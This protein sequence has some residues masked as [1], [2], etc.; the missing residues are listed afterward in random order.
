M[1]VDIL[2]GH[3]DSAVKRYCTTKFNKFNSWTYSKS[4]RRKKCLAYYQA[5]SEGANQQAVKDTY[6]RIF[7]EAFPKPPVSAEQSPMLVNPDDWLDHQKERIADSRRVLTTLQM[8]KDTGEYQ[9]GEEFFLRLKQLI[10]EFD[11]SL[12]DS[13]ELRT[14]SEA[15][16]V[17]NLT[18]SSVRNARDV[19]AQFEGMIGI[20]QNASVVFE[21]YSPNW[22]EINAKLEE[23]FKG[24]IWTSG[25]AKA[26]IERLGF[27]AEVQAAIAIGAQLTIAGECSWKKG[28]AGLELGGE[29]QAFAGARAELGGKLSVSALKG[30]EL[31][32]KGGAFVGVSASATG[33]VAFTYGDE[34]LVRVTAEATISVGIGAEFEINIAAPIFGPSKVK[35]KGEVTFGVGGGSAVELEVNF[36]E[37]GLA[38]SE[39]FRKV[40][41]LPTL[42]KGY[43]MTLM[44][45][46]RRNKHYLDKC[47][48]RLGDG[49]EEIEESLAAYHNVPVEKRRL[50]MEMDY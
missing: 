13:R 31:A 8:W 5:A 7:K 46:D 35:V 17:S 43:K 16:L 40:V 32:L 10:A 3:S 33:T 48:R 23:E 47:Q 28:K 20:Q 4:T 29:C 26:K 39:Q 21:A 36:T 6:F 44:T 49:M 25:E 24:G 11:P 37:M 45:S 34:D 22:G 41:Y 1:R 12:C 2:T 9:T 42:M 15:R 50:L 18:G 14:E 27:S 38:A 19:S 30:V